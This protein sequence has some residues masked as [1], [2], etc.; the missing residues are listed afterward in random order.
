MAVPNSKRQRRLQRAGLFVGLAG[1][2][3]VV[4]YVLAIGE[5]PFS[6]Y[7]LPRVLIIG[8]PFLIL[9]G[10]AWKWPVT[11]GVLLI[12]AGLFW[13]IWRLTTLYSKVSSMSFGNWLY[14]VA[15][16]VLPVSLPMLT[17]GIFFLFSRRYLDEKKG[18]DSN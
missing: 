16:G 7:A 2:V 15:I 1:V 14:F 5:A 12:A 3:I 4:I 10:V 18:M 8:L 9:V 17:C 13:P 6:I 11:G